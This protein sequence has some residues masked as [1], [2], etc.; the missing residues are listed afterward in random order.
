MTK[1]EIITDETQRLPIARTEGCVARLIRYLTFSLLKREMMPMNIKNGDWARHPG[2]SYGP[3]KVIDQNWALLAVAIQFGPNGGI[4]V[5]PMRKDTVLAS[6][7]N[8]D[9]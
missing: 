2:W 6:E 5:W 3:V 7:P 9:L 4:A 1:T 8:A